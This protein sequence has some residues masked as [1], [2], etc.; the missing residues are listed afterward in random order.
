MHQH[1]YPYLTLAERQKKPR[2]VGRTLVQDKG[3]SLA[4]MK[5]VLETT[6]PYIDY[7]KQTRRC[8]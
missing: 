6:G 8:L 1:T 4:D 7:Y 3:A 2:K 5:N